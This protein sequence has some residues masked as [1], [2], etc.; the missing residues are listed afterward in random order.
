[1][2]LVDNRFK[3]ETPRKLARPGMRHIA[4]EEE[5]IEMG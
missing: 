1:V 5:W 2:A 4:Q 3:D